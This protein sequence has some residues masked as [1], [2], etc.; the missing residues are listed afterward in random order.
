MFDQTTAALLFPRWATLGVELVFG[1]FPLIVGVLD[2]IRVGFD[3][4]AGGRALSV[5]F[6]IL[7]IVAGALLLAYPL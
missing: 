1:S 3:R 2:L 6:G 4:P 5:I 7:A